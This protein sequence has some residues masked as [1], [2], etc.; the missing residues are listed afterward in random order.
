MRSESTQRLE[1]SADAVLALTSVWRAVHGSI[2]GVEDA[3]G[4]VDGY[5]RHDGIWTDTSEDTRKSLHQAF[6]TLGREAPP[7]FAPMWFVEAGTA[8]LLWNAGDV[9]LEDGTSIA[10]IEQL[11]ADLPLGYHWLIPH[12]GWPPVRLVV[13]PKRCPVAIR[14]WGVAAQLYAA[15]SS[16]SWGIGDLGDL[17]RLARTIDGFVL[18][19]PLHGG[20]PVKPMQDSPYYS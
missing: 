16:Q 13:T 9:E 1:S 7:D 4:V 8:P 5:H 6:G 15:R 12:D 10:G 14:R 2:D 19:S 11:P 20:P 18:T 17:R 3:W